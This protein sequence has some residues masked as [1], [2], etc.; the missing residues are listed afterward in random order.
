VVKKLALKWDCLTTAPVSDRPQQLTTDA[1]SPSPRRRASFNVPRG[2]STA[3][4]NVPRGYQGRPSLRPNNGQFNRRQNYGGNPQRNGG[5]RGSNPQ[6]M[7]QQLGGGSGPC[8]KCGR[9]SHPHP[10]YCPVINKTCNYCLKLGH[11]P[12]VCRSAA[13]ERQ[14][15]RQ[16]E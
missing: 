3:D 11:F 12:A 9:R 6:V 14:R 15:Q 16:S 8:S 1:R 10:N 7:P 5:W 2:A 13:R 4:Y